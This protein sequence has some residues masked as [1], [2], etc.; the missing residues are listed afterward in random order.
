MSCDGARSIELLLGPITGVLGI[1]CWD[2]QT[3]ECVEHSLPSTPALIRRGAYTAR[4]YFCSQKIHRGLWKVF[5]TR[6]HT[7]TVRVLGELDVIPI[8]S[9]HY[10]NV[11]RWPPPAELPKFEPRWL[12][13]R[14]Q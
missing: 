13:R 4:L 11:I 5:E 1:E 2:R 10:L 6:Y 9:P 8:E 14:D 3:E 7:T 12:R